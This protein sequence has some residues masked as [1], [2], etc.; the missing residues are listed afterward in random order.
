M[1]Y[2][3]KV[4]VERFIAKF[5]SFP[6]EYMMHFDSFWKWKLKV[7]TED[8]HILDDNHRREAYNRLCYILPRWQTYRSSRNFHP[9][10]TL[11]SSLE[12]MSDAYDEI[13][14]HSLP[15]LSN[16]PCQPLEVIWHELGRV[17]EYNGNRND[18]GYYYIISVCKPLMLI[19]GQTLAFDS[20]V[21]KNTPYYV[22]KT[23]TRWTFEE[24]KEVMKRF[25]ERL[26]QDSEI[27]GFFKEKSLEK[28][29]NDLIVPYGRF[30]DIY[31]Y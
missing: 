31:Y 15:E 28:Y 9:L 14:M 19:W 18:A 27:V 17:K 24:W 26:Q 7:E 25:Q 21:R 8:E 13:R 29:G 11:K 22:L 5:S 2:V 16:A 30:L 4:N 3:D 12:T 6:S 20:H 10:I 23:R 1:V